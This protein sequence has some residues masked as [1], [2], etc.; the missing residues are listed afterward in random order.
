MSAIRAPGTSLPYR[1]AVLAPDA[2]RVRAIATPDPVR[3]G[4]LRVPTLG[5]IA[6]G[7][8]RS[9][10]LVAIA[11]L[12]ILVLLPAALVAAATQVASAV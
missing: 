7:A 10:V 2:Y 8:L 12:L 6:S 3:G 5:P 1:P 4:R 11:M 9:L